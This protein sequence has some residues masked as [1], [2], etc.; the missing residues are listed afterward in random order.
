[1]AFQLT[2]IANGAPQSSASRDQ[3]L[4]VAISQVARIL[5]G[6]RSSSFF[7]REILPENATPYPIRVESRSTWPV[8]RLLR[9]FPIAKSRRVRR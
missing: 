9:W 4:Y 3:H 2:G 8:V 6:E 7:L 5:F 1:M